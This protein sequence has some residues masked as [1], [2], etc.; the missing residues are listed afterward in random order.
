LDNKENG[1]EEDAEIASEN[2]AGDIADVNYRSATRKVTY[3]LVEERDGNGVCV[4]VCVCV[5]V[6]VC[7]CVCV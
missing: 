6:Y 4:C 2:L 3:V 5:F 7:L 1:H